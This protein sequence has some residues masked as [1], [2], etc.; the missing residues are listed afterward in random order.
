MCPAQECKQVHSRRQ[1]WV[2]AS[3]SPRSQRTDA[4]AEAA[5]LSH[6][7]RPYAHSVHPCLTKLPNATAAC[8][9][10][11]SVKWLISRSG[12]ERDQHRGPCFCIQV[13]V[14]VLSLCSDKRSSRSM[15]L[16]RSQ[17]T[18][19][20][21]LGLARL[22]ASLPWRSSRDRIVGLGASAA[23]VVAPTCLHSDRSRATGR[24][25]WHS[26][27]WVRDWVTTDLQRSPERAPTARSAP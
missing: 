17:R 14:E 19:T 2:P 6:G 7:C 13:R 9:F 27:S 10:Q 18:T 5:K 4:S 1:R 8:R 16:G 11:L 15:L 25:T 26:T 12:G 21:S 3:R 24:C 23:S 22:D 20:S